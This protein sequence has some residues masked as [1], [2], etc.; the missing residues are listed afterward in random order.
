[1][2]WLSAEPQYTVAA[3]LV[4]YDHII[5]KSSLDQNDNVADLVRDPSKFVTDAVVDANVAALP[6]GARLQFM[7]RG[8]FIVDKPYQS[9]SSPAE[10]IYI[11]DGKQSKGSV[12]SSKVTL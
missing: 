4:E 10:L 12:L 5:T 9:E 1:M 6:K 7:R 3:K 2:T 8:Y 11:P